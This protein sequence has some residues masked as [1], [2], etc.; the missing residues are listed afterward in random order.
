MASLLA[1]LSGGAVTGALMA[2]ALDDP[3]SATADRIKAIVP[4]IDPGTL[5]GPAYANA[6]AGTCLTW[7]V[8]A[9]ERVTAFTTIDCALPH[10]FEVAGRIDLNEVP[11]FG[12]GSAL[13]DKADL[14]PVGT[15][16]CMPVVDRYTG[17]REID[18]AGRFTGLVVPPSEEGW[19]KGDHAVLCGIA[20]AELDGRSA[21]SVGRFVEADQHRRWDAGTCLGFTTEGLPGAPVPCSDDHSI[22]I[23]SDVDVS[24]IFAEGPNPPEPRVQSELTAEAC[25]QAGVTYLGD[26]EALRRSTLISTLVHPIAQVSWATG[27][28]TVNCGLMKSNDQGAFA[29]LRG[30]AQQGVLVDGNTPVA[31]TTTAIPLPGAAA[32]NGAAASEGIPSGDGSAPGIVP[33]PDQQGGPVGTP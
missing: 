1:V 2:S 14:A 6:V 9:Q 3:N 13:P 5:S 21:T 24:G 25:Y 28:R 8:D 26:P 23:I 29:V 17:G 11:G 4:Q 22:E 12:S 15:D 30:S 27:S 10:R 32:D 18:P 20:S 7:S 31:P 33:V 16:R 19:N